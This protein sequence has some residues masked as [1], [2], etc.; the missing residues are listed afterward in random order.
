MQTGKSIVTVVRYKKV[1]KERGKNEDHNLSLSLEV[2]DPKSSN[3]QCCFLAHLAMPKMR[4][5]LY[6]RNL[7]FVLYV[8]LWMP[9]SVDNSLS[10]KIYRSDR[11]NGH[12]VGNII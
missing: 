11:P 9:V 3:S 4:L 1:E 10:V 12:P 2:F 7:S 5:D 6:D 8:L